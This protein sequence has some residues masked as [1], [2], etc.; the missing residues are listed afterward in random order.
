LALTYLKAA[1]LSLS[2]WLENF[3]HRKQGVTFINVS[4]HEL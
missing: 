2:R 1:Q 3:S 4:R